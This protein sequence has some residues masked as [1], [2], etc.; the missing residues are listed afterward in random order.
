M[1]YNSRIKREKKVKNGNLSKFGQHLRLVVKHRHEVFKNCCK[2]G[3]F[4]RGLVHDLSKFSRVE[5][6]E[7]VKYFNGKKSPIVFCRKENGYSKAWIHHKNHNKH[8]IEYWYDNEN[9]VQMSIPYKYAVE[10]V[11]DKIAATKC[12]NGKE[13]KPENVLQYWEKTKLTVQTND[14][15]K[16]F[17]TKV[18]EDLITVGEKQILNKKYMKKTYKEIVEKKKV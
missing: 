15:M 2:C 9:A 7:S 18:F 5:F 6:W 14:E 8:H 16:A 17:F 3:L 4:W 10:S 1:C 13:Y 11:C 12:Y